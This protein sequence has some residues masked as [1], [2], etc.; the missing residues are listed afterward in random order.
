ML[1]LIGHFCIGCYW[2]IDLL[3]CLV[4]LLDWSIQFLKIRQSTNA[5]RLIS[6]L[7]CGY[8]MMDLELLAL[9]KI[10]T[11]ILGLL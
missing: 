4:M 7:L 11:L 10:F 3:F 8:G 9:G 1:G 6:G 2:R 5:R